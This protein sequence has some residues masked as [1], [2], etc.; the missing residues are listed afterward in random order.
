MGQPLAPVTG[1]PPPR[2]RYALAGPV[3]VLVSFAAAEAAAR[4][5]RLL[6]AC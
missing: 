5:G 4:G 2:V 6:Y 3:V 1:V